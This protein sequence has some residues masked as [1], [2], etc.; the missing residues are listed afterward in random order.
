MLCC[1]GDLVEDVVVWPQAELRHGTDTP[2]LI[3]R[4]RGGSA[5]T[6]AVYA[7]AAGISARFVGRVGNDRL[8][9]MLVGELAAAGVDTRV[10]CDGT[11]G[12][13]VVL[14]DRAGERTMLPD[15]AAAT[16]LDDLPPGALDGI[17]W[18]HVPAYSLVVEPLG[19]TSLGAVA[20]ARASEC[21]VSVDASSVG[22]L[23]EFGVG[24]FLTL[25]ERLAPD[26]FFCNRDEA[27][28]LGAGVD[29]PIP[30]ADLTIVKAGAD[31]VTLIGPEGAIAR[32]E[33]PPVEEVNDTTGAGDAFAAGFIAA[34]LN[35]ATP[36]A[37]AEAGCRL[38]ATV[39]TSPGA[40]SWEEQ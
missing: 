16:E 20:T 21:P 19:T 30:G 36:S 1:I 27:D 38:A 35:S 5:A 4:Q 2:A 28:L 18:L 24:R 37:A 39:L 14:V 31:P 17:T 9:S 6:V 34:T 8:G 25:V 13:I 33:V 29:A 32:V 40:G 15:R 23:E 7:V 22:P 11:T 12:S 3:F 10:T 26:V